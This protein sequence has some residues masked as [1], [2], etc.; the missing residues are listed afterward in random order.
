MAQTI[1][2]KRSSTGGNVPATDDLALGEMAINTNDGLMFIKKDVSG[3]ETICTFHSTIDDTNDRILNLERGSKANF[4]LNFVDNTGTLANTY[5][6]GNSGRITASGGGMTLAGYGDLGLYTNGTATLGGETATAVIVGGSDCASVTINTSLTG[7]CELPSKVRF[8]EDAILQARTDDPYP[9]FEMKLEHVN[10]NVSN[11]T[12][13]EGLRVSSYAFGVLHADA[14]DSVTANESYSY[15]VATLEG[16][17]NVKLIADYYQT[18]AN[19]GY[20]IRPY[21]TSSGSKSFKATGHVELGGNVTQYPQVIPHSNSR[22]YLGTSSKKWYHV[23]ATNGNFIN[24]YVTGFL[25]LSDYDYLRF[26][27]SDD[28]KMYYNGSGN[29]MY[30]ELEYQVNNFIIVDQ[31]TSNVRFTF[32]RTTGNFTASGNVTAYSDERLKSDIKTLDPSKTLQMRGV[33]FI[34]DGKKGSGVV[35]Q[36]LEKIAPELVLDEGD[37]KSVAYGNLS[38]YLIETIKD[39]Q[40]QIDELKELVH[41][42]LEK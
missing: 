32:E 39:Q 2:L 7:Y 20:Y 6:D 30:M 21:T 15:T 36:E 38:G 4:V 5:I 12:F 18:R 10:E 3:T 29:Q 35:A 42:L 9:T 1:K 22:G 13:T 25:D 31:S 17:N 19:S 16:T 41:K 14:V 40:K 27:S 11:L 33:E 24:L 23:N 28:V 26:G 37:Y 34:K 8:S